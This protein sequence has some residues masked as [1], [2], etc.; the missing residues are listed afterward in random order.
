MRLANGWRLR[1]LAALALNVVFLS[2]PVWAQV[3]NASVAGTI[4]DNTGAALPG[5]TITVTSP[6]LQVP[7]LVRVSEADG[8]Y[9]FVDL[10]VGTYRLTYELSGFS[11]LARE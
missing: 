10:P 4:T 2:P 5:V 11:R 1:T 9:Q 7:Q 3:R 8:T 6:A